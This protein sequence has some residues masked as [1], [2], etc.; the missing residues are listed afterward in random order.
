MYPGQNIS[1]QPSVFA[2][3]STGKSAN[4]IRGFAIYSAWNIPTVK[5]QSFANKNQPPKLGH[6]TLATLQ[7]KKR[8]MKVFLIDE[9]S[10]F[11]KINMRDI[12]MI[13][14]QIKENKPHFVGVC[15]IAIGDFF[16]LPP[17]I[18]SVVFQLSK[19]ASVH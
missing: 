5:F 4:N 3:A 12:D 17:V 13:M 19:G 16:Q 14:K 11:N 15:T 6:A 2:T 10:I 8:Y 1:K 18:P 7:R 9:M